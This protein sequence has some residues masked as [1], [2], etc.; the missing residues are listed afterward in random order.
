[1]SVI[2]TSNISGERFSSS[3]NRFASTIEIITENVFVYYCE[4]PI[5]IYKKLLM[6]S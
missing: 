2:I 3:R 5:Q 6:I 1:M 4:I